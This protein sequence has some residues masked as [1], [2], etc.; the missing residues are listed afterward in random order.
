MT[1]R[2]RS[3]PS[4]VTASTATR[5]VSPMAGA[6]RSTRTNG[7]AT[8]AGTAA[9]AAQ[10]LTPA[11]AASRTDHTNRRAITTVPHP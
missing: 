11:T 6:R 9:T 10:A 7:S 2:R 4:G 5:D 8:G 1:T 3:L